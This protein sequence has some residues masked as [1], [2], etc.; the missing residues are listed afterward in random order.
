MS[1]QCEYC[2]HLERAQAHRAELELELERTRAQVRHLLHAMAHGAGP[3]YVTLAQWANERGYSYSRVWQ[4]A[5][6]H[7]NSLPEPSIPGGRGHTFWTRWVLDE[8]WAASSRPAKKTAE[9]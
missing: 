2:P 7:R 4:R 5:H 1:E 3:E 9:T 6:R 8:W